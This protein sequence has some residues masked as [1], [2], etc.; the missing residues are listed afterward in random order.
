MGTRAASQMFVSDRLLNY[1]AAL[2]GFDRGKTGQANTKLPPRLR[3]CA[4]LAGEPFSALVGHVNKWVDAVVYHRNDIAH[5]LGRRPRGSAA[6][7]H[8]LAESAY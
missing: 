8:Y 1:T 7:Q 2:E 3:R 6:E 4:Q 5:H